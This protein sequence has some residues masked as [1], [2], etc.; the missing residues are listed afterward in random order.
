[1][2]T[3]IIDALINISAV[4]FGEFTLK[5]G[6]KSPIY[7]DL[8]IIISYPEL[9]KDIASVLVEISKELEYTKVAGIPYTALPIATA[10]SIATDTPMI[11]SRKEKKEY[12]T[13]KQIEGVWQ[14]GET[15]LLVDDLIT[16]GESK[17]ETFEVFEQAGLTIKDVVVLIDREQGGRE[18][19]EKGGYKLHSLIS[20]FEIL[21]RMKELNKLDDEQYDRIHKFLTTPPSK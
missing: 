16:N 6:I 7:I 20:I 21:E 3:K 2:K 4:K 13:S 15:V 8:R 17:L 18:L 9:L 5:S 19:L 10:F 11:Y 14:E 1:M 12:G